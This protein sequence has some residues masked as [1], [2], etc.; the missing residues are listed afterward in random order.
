MSSKI[1]PAQVLPFYE[2]KAALTR[3][4]TPVKTLE[5]K[6][7]LATIRHLSFVRP[8]AHGAIAII[9]FNTVVNVFAVNYASVNEPL[10][11]GAIMRQSPG[12]ILNPCLPKPFGV[13][14]SVVWV[15]VIAA[16][17]NV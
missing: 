9:T 2:S 5:S 1:Q 6:T 13:R 17:E 3:A 12:V 10:K 16:S 7:Y 14:G 4:L 11:T 8:K 15:K